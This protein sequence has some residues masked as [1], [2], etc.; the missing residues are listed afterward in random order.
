LAKSI[1][2]L[3]GLLNRVNQVRASL[4]GLIIIE[5]REEGWS[6]LEC[7]AVLHEIETKAVDICL[8]NNRA[9][10]AGGTLIVSQC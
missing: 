1:E 2:A 7:S 10:T 8:R 3:D 6:W 9:I 4:C 5:D